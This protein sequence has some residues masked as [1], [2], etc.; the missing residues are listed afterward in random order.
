MT[1]EQL[2]MTAKALAHPARV[3]IVRLL[4]AQSECRGHDVFAGLPLAQ[5]TISQHLRVLKSAGVIRSHA[6][7]TSMVYCLNKPV[8]E[9]FLCA[10]G[11]IA[12]DAATCDPEQGDDR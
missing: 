4:A 6:V 3:R 12:S 10:L 2:A 1:E 9:E 7:G 8:L 11:E 5:S